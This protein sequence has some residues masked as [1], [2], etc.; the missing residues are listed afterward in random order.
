LRILLDTHVLLWWLSDDQRLS[1]SARDLILDGSNEILVSAATGWE[2]A[3]KSA[4]GKLI[5]EGV[6]EAFVDEQGFTKLPITLAHT[7]E[8][9]RLP[10]I[11][12]DPFDRMLVA[13][14]RVENL[15]ILT[16]D[17]NILQYPANVLEA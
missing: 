14:T 2:I 13:Q 5:F 17:Q 1:G 15:Q 9:S 6:L 8:I 7:S 11:H 16:V 12:R 3:I 4:L 10:P